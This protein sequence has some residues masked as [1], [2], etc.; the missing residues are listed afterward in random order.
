MSE[1]VREGGGGRERVKTNKNQQCIFSQYK[2]YVSSSVLLS[3][4]T[5]YLFFLEISSFMY[6]FSPAVIW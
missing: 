1:G 3:Y 6:L 4:Y 2:H 5:Y